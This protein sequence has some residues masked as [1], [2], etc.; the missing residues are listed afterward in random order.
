M[1]EILKKLNVQIY[2]DGADLKN[3]IKLN[4]NN[5]VKG[6]TTNPSLM[7]KSG[8]NDYEKYSKKILSNISNKPVSFEVFGDEDN[9]IVEQ[10]KKIA[11]WGKNVYVKVPIINSKGV[12]TKKSIENLIIENIN[13]NI[14]AI[15]TKEQ[16]MEILDIINGK[17]QII[18]SVFA[19]RIA[20]A[21]VDP[22][23]IIREIVD[24]TKHLN[25]V[26]ILWAS[27][28]ETY[29]IFQADRSNCHIITI[30]HGKFNKF[31]LIGKNLESY[32][33][34]TVKMFLDDATSS[35]FKI[36]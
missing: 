1:S 5:L 3:I 8:V 27:F 17:S 4:N 34:D 16:V 2:A 36:S 31:D 32:S 11:S 12:S 21:G 9:E 20:D 28:R 29:N 15:F 14:T 35:N 25:N 22:E 23:K 30:E 33:K 24:I 13:L 7:V 26:K 19:G 18:L 10:G 6:F